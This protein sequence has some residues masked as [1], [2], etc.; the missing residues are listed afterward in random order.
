M[1]LQRR[2]MNVEIGERA[3]KADNGC[4]TLTVD[5]RSGACAVSWR[6]GAELSG[7][8][9]AYRLMSGEI[10]TTADYAEHRAGADAACEIED[11]VG[12]RGVRITV[13]HTDAGAGRPVLRQQFTVY[14][15]QPF[16]TVRIALE[17][18]AG[19]DME[20]NYTAPLLAKNPATG[21]ARL[22]L[23]D[24]HELRALFVPFDNDKWV[25]YA[26]VPMPGELESYEATAVYDPASRKGLVLGSLTH[27]TWKTGLKL[28][29]AAGGRMDA[30]EVYGGAAGE[31]TRDSIPHGA[32][33]GASVQS[34]VI[35]LGSYADYRDGLEAFGRANAAIRPALPWEHGV[36]LGWNSWSA[37]ADKLDYD[38]YVKTSD[39]LHSL[40]DKGFEN[41][42]IVYIN[43]DSFWTSLSEDQLRQA[44]KHVRS[45]GQKAGIYWT[46]FAYWGKDPDCEVEGT[47]GRY[48]YAELLLKDREGNVLPDL[49][50]GLAIDPTHPGNLM[51]TDYHLKRF[52]E[53]GF[54]YVKLDFLGH[55]A[56]EGSHYDPAVQTG[57]Q[58]YNLGMDYICRSLAPERIGR[59]F[60]INLSIAPIFPHG[61]GHSRRISCDAFGTLA[62]TEY[63][64]NSLTYGWWL[65]D[66]VYRFNDPDHT[67]LYKSF[68]QDATGY[69]EGRSRLNASAIAGTVLLMGDDFRREEAR[70]RASEWLANA[71][72]LSLA[73]LGR[74]F[75]PVESGAG[76]GATDVFML[77][78]EAQG[79]EEI[80]LAVF[81]FDP[82]SPAQKRIP[83]ERLGFTAGVPAAYTATDLWTGAS[84][85]GNG[86]ILLPLEAGE[87]TLIKLKF[88]SAARE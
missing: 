67:V 72:L 76:S 24:G 63:M 10:G 45:N 42:G 26:S 54:D 49:D 8:L 65:N 62:D 75:V 36:P 66:T 32:V 47:G 31:Q 30:I 78:T 37:V 57:I 1:S 18:T 34:P 17:G 7:I 56:L 20:T 48:T 80:V 59:P 28:S 14:E 60:H 46:P 29:S 33:K 11:A 27:D 83:L 58:A 86:D 40:K 82:T 19:G 85:G 41:D 39:F 9:S 87:S 38:L 61:Y 55:G 52:V 21:A 64:L 88:C 68:N 69:H 22:G 44:V 70:V 53:W 2:G 81:N 3:I 16:L 4:L 77:R 25:R 12:G 5:L 43:F 51:R 50:G 84:R 79:E 35:F 6:D 13:A 74:T 15:R 73:R 23:P 71:K